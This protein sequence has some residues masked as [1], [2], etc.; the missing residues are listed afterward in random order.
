M[1]SGGAKKVSENSSEKEENQARPLSSNS[2]KADHYRQ[3]LRLKS[4]SESFIAVYR[5]E[6]RYR[7]LRF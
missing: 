5:N 1:H 4:D 2:F 6:K 3:K 7:K